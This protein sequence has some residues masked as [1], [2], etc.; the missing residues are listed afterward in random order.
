MIQQ[1][2]QAGNGVEQTTHAGLEVVWI[3]ELIASDGGRITALAFREL[4]KARGHA[5]R[6]MDAARR[7]GARV[8]IRRVCIN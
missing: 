1:V 2:D 4:D 7:L 5:D 8:E 6:C 3:V